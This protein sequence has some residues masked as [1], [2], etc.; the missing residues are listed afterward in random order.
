MTSS[1]KSISQNY[2][3]IQKLV[4]QCET[5]NIK[6]QNN[7]KKTKDLHVSCLKILTS[8]LVGTGLRLARDAP[9]QQVLSSGAVSQSTQHG[10]CRHRAVAA[11]AVGLGVGSHAKGA[12]IGLGLV[13]ETDHSV[14]GDGPPQIQDVANTYGEMAHNFFWGRLYQNQ[15]KSCFKTTWWLASTYSKYEVI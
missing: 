15:L 10:Q 5:V 1:G 12:V 4:K 9:S 11:A 2:P 8:S 13:D 3:K 6:P 7:Y 14:H